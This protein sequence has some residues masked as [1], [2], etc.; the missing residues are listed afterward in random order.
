MSGLDEHKETAKIVSFI[1]NGDEKLN[2]EEEFL[3][4]NMTV[5]E[6]ESMPETLKAEIIYTRSEYGNYMQMTTK[7]IWKNNIF[8][9]KDIYSDET[10]LARLANNLIYVNKSVSGKEKGYIYDS[11]TDTIYKVSKTNIG[12]KTVHSLNYAKFIID[13][14]KAKGRVIEDDVKVATATDGTK[15]YEPDLNNFTYTTEIVYY[16]S[17]LKKEKTISVEEY[18][19][20]NKPSTITINGE[21]YIFANYAKTGTKIWANIKTT[22]NGIPA[23]WVW[24]PRYAYKLNQDTQKSDVIYVDTDDKPLD[25][26][27]YGSTLPE[28]YTVHEGFNQ[29]DGL[30][31]IWFSKYQPSIYE[32]IP[33]DNAEG[34]KP[35]LSNFNTEKTKLIYYT[36]NLGKTLE[37]NYTQNPERVITEGGDT[38]YFYD[39]G[40]KIWP[41]IKTEANEIIAYW[42]WIP[43]YAYKLEAGNCKVILIDENDKPLDTEKYGESLPEGYTVHEG[44]RQGD[45][46]KGVWFSKYQP[47]KIEV[48]VEETE[49]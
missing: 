6:I 18:I 40:K 25:T 23:Y 48:E 39:Y 31:G 5:S 12:T 10:E 26:E 47:S 4:N 42:V 36:A 46:L 44:F 11:V 16:S 8:N 21:I 2:S 33:V 45:G 30:K 19:K 38:Y 1:T 49:E 3:S 20:Q 28:G 32:T 27:T 22:A 14:I 37:K 15:Y 35:D 41:N 17:D 13:G 43:R 7:H 34:N 24:I 9:C 29:S